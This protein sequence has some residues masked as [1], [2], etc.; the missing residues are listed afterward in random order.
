MKKKTVKAIFR[1]ANGSLGYQTNH[2]YLLVIF[3]LKGQNIAI[4]IDNQN[5][6]DN[7]HDGYCE[8]ESIVS[9]LENWDN[10][11]VIL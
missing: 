8:Y 7:T 4:R 9:F 10:I 11:R 3:Q 1:G 2:E 6:N 5:Q